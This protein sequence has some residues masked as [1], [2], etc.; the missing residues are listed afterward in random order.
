MAEGELQLPRRHAAE[1]PPA[2]LKDYAL[3]PEHDE[4]RNK[5]RVFASALGIR[6]EDWECLADSL[7]CGPLGTARG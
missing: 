5:A 6:Q 2:K 3:N 4:G 7:R 1:I